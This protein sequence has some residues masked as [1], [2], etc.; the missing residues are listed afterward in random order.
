MS[1]V[2]SVHEHEWL[3]QHCSRPLA[4]LLAAL[5]G[6]PVIANRASITFRS[7]IIPGYI[8]TSFSCVFVSGCH[9]HTESHGGKQFSIVFMI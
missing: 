6:F 7:Y 9:I 8:K 5:N 3:M 2:E 4:N 1:F